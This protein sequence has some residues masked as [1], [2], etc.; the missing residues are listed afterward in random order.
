MLQQ[1]WERHQSWLRYVPWVVLLVILVAG[2][3]GDQG[4]VRLRSLEQDK[5]NLEASIRTHEATNL[6]L[7][8][9]VYYL[10]HDA[11]YLEKVAREEMGLVRPGEVVYQFKD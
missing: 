10:R 3:L 5:R 8:R 11:K 4:I 1:L 2:L 7:R 6:K 9:E